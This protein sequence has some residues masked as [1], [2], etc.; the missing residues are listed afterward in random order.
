MGR[1]SRKVVALPR[2]KGWRILKENAW[3][4]KG[5]RKKEKRCEWR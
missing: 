1:R 4:K 3:R 2:V 5:R